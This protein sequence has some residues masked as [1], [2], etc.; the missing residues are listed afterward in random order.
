MDA[1]PAENGLGGELRMRDPAGNGA[2]RAIW[3]R[4]ES[5]GCGSRKGERMYLIMQRN[6]SP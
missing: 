3:P 5:A 6:L 1:F 4:P 2:D